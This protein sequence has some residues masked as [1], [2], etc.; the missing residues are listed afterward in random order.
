MSS[1]ACTHRC[2][3]PISVI[4]LF[5]F[6]TSQFWCQAFTPSQSRYRFTKPWTNYRLT[7]T[8]ED[9]QISVWQQSGEEWIEIRSNTATLPLEAQ[10]TWAWCRNFVVPLQLCPWARASVETP[11]ALQIFLVDPN[12]PPSLYAN[13]VKDVGQNFQLFLAKNPTIES[14]AI[15]FVIFPV[16]EF[17]SFYDWFLDLEETWDLM[18]SVIVAP[19]HPDWAFD[20]E[21]DN[22]QYEKRSPFP[23]VSLVS[24]NVVD[25]AGEVATKRIGEHNEQLLL[26]KSVKE[27]QSLW[28]QCLR[29]NVDWE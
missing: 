20:G 9:S 12:Y 22:L 4:G 18:D 11:T 21:L 16:N 13:I 14:A 25:A 27:L 26:S 28:D 17:G 2:L 3:S 23:T 7:P 10:Q 6:L 19:F 8:N 1:I 24:T 15:F 29:P 5:W